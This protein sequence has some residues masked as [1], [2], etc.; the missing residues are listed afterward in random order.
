MLDVSKSHPFEA[1]AAF[2]VRLLGRL[3]A[4]DMA[5]AEALIDVNDTGAPFAESFPAPD[6]FTYADP[7]QVR[8]WSMHVLG[9]SERGLGLDFEVPFGEAEYE[10]R[11]LSA[12]FDMRRVGD[13]LE[14]RLTGAV[15][16]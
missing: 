1:C 5:G 6:G 14:V 12:R 11:A 9:A 15:P 16:N 3:A 4:G 2:A 13:A 7:T 8:D 10:G